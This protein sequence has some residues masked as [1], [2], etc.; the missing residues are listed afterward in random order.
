[1]GRPATCE[2]GECN[3]CKHRIYMRSW[4]RNNRERVLSQISERR[5]KGHMAARETDKYH[6]DAE[7]RRR[8]IARNAIGIRLRRGTMERGSCEICHEPNAQAHHHDYDR[9]LDVTWL[10]EKHH[11]QLHGERIAA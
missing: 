5:K 11:R 8:K 10:C 7:F 6:N 4:Y 2:C 3:K 9:P 1:M